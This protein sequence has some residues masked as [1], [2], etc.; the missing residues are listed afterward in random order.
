MIAP[1]FM[2]YAIYNIIIRRKTSTRSISE[3]SGERGRER[4]RPMMERMM[5]REEWTQ[6]WPP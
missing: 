6:R 1:L 2:L 4:T 5:R 3:R